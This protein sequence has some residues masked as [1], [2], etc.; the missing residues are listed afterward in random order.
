MKKVTE[1]EIKMLFAALD[2]STKYNAYLDC[3]E[4]HKQLGTWKE[5]YKIIHERHGI[6]PNTMRRIRSDFTK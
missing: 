6:P 4:L 5:T 2:K 3:V 1:T